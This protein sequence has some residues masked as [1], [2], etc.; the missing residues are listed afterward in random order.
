MASQGLPL[1]RA[2][3]EAIHAE[4]QCKIDDLACQYR[5][6]EQQAHAELDEKL[7]AIVATFETQ[8]AQIASQLDQSLR[9]S[10]EQVLS[11]KR[12]LE[13]EA[14]RRAHQEQADARKKFYDEQKKQYE[15]ELFTAITAL[16][17]AGG[18]SPLLSLGECLPFYC[19]NSCF[20]LRRVGVNRPLFHRGHQKLFI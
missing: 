3:A 18:V 13:I 6:Q 4:V 11:Q 7:A 12:D 20:S 10:I 16:M 1:E 15:K 2:R 9:E 8:R 14:L 19:A 5:A 17:V